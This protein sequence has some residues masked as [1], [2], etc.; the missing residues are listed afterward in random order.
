MKRLSIGR[1]FKESF[2]KALRSLETG[3]SG[4]TSKIQV[5]NGDFRRDLFAE[6]R[7]PGADRILYVADGFRNNVSIEEMYDA[8]RIDPWFLAQIHELVQSEQSLQGRTIRDVKPLELRT[9][10]RDDFLI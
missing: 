5:Q 4:L 1:T 7:Q 3:I 8:T 9:L 6:L 10:K 2:Q